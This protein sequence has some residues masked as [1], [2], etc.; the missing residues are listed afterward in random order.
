VLRGAKLFQYNSKEPSKYYFNSSTMTFLVQPCV[1]ADAHDIATTNMSAWYEDYHWKYR[2]QASLEEIIKWCEER[3]PHLLTTERETK[4]HQKVV[5]V[6]TG[7]VVGYARWLLPTKLAEKNV[8]PEAQAAEPN[9]RDVD[10]F[11]KK[12]NIAS[13]KLRSE[14]MN[15]YRSRPLE[16]TDERIRKMGP[17]LGELT[18]PICLQ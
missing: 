6:A 1:P 10:L 4:R 11:A 7:E 2:W 12:W 13:P 3:F 16:E 9:T 14:E 15:M 17:F 18:R 8:W 5:D